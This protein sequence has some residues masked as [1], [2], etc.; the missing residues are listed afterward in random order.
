MNSNI[1]LNLTPFGHWTLRN[2]AALGG[3]YV[4]HH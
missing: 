4:S 2:K 3:L 1:A